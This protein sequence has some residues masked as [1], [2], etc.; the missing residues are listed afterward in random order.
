MRVKLLDYNSRSKKAVIEVHGLNY[1]EIIEFLARVQLLGEMKYK[2][3]TWDEP[4]QHITLEPLDLS[5]LEGSPSDPSNQD[6][7]TQSTTSD[8]EEKVDLE[9]TLRES[10]KILRDEVEAEEK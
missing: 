8:A 3:E 6:N 1:D 10:V 4:A 7:K 9:K 5:N 2:S